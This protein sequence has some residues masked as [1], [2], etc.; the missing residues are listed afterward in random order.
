LSE[1][2]LGKG[3]CRAVSQ[4]GRLFESY[5]VAKPERDKHVL[6]YEIRAIDNAGGTF[7]VA[8]VDTATAAL[9]KNRDAN[10]AHR[11]AW[12]VDDNNQEIS[13]DELLRRSFEERNGALG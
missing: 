13:G 10:R 4:L 1:W 9:M 8:T 11:R 5:A 12:V 3:N 6:V 7:I 2:R